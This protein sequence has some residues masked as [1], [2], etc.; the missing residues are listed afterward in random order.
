MP[1][2]GQPAVR[3]TAANSGHCVVTRFAPS[4]TGALHVGGARTALFSWA[5][6]RR[7]GG[8]F[9]LRM[10]DTDQKRSSEA[11]AKSIIEDLRWLGLDWDGEIY[12]QSQHLET[13]R[14]Q[15]QRLLGAGRAYR[16][17]D[18]IRFRMAKD[19]VVV[20]DAVLG[21]VTFGPEQLEDFII[22]KSDGFP[23]FHF[24]VVVDDELMGVTHVIRG[25][26]HLANTPKHLALQEALGFRRPVY[27]HLS[28]ILNADGSKMS[29]RDKAKAARA[30]A[31]KWLEEHGGDAAALAGAGAAVQAIGAERLRAFLAK[32]ND[33]ADIAQA[34]AA[35]MGL[36]L[37]EIE[38]HDFRE[39]GYYPETLVNYLALLGWS[40]PGGEERFDR[41]FL[42]RAFDL[43][44]VSKSNARFDRDKL[45]AFNEEAIAQRPIGDLEALLRSL[46]PP[47]H[48]LR[49][50][51]QTYQQRSGG[52]A[53]DI[54]L[55]VMS[56]IQEPIYDPKAV[57]KVLLAKEGAG[58]KVLREVRPI[59]A[60]CPDFD[61]RTIHAALERFAG[62]TGRKIGDVAQPLRVAVTG[63]TVSPPIDET[64]AI[65]M[66]EKGR[67]AVLA[68]I[69]VAIARHSTKDAP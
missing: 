4:P 35:A 31:K 56:L 10:E 67:E 52:T 19:P 23:T 16:D 58:L 7:H 12:Y 69:D 57:Q 28:S 1:P 48:N 33:D 37:P 50:I 62:E 29:K 68:R 21:D 39:S 64:L 34:I 9:L 18:A 40:P 24:A 36:S 26:E 11:S 45:R 49:L 46:G 15:A 59:L 32:E 55:R 65:V 3:A 6:A 44:R 13:Y 20:P 42:A 8:R 41:H 51:A 38:V 17:G 47:F 53:K 14:Q 30:A 60:A 66:N 2:E 25:Q 61:P 43:S 27:A 63:S 22:I 54:L 5:F